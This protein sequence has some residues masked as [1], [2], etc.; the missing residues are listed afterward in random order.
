MHEGQ[1]A[2]RRAERFG[3]VLPA[4]VRSRSGFLDR[5]TITDLSEWGC[6]IESRALT[7]HKTDLVVVRPEGIEGICGRVCWIDGHT[8]G[9]EF[10]RP[11]YAPVVE[12]LVR[13]HWQFLAETG[14]R[15]VP[16]RMVA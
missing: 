2:M 5:V 1:V 8:A 12:H 9:I 10:D 4:K 13:S 6:R 15:P 14:G 7:L 16:L 3:V 11:L